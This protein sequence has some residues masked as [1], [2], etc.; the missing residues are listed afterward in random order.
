M[1]P[2][3]FLS[4]GFVTFKCNGKTICVSV[5]QKGQQ[6]KTAWSNTNTKKKTVAFSKTKV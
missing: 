1:W 4:H 5:N 3:L 2:T 6:P